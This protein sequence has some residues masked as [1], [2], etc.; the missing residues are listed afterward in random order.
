MSIKV[1][2]LRSGVILHCDQEG[3]PYLA[4]L[5]N[6]QRVRKRESSLIWSWQTRRR[7]TLTVVKAAERR[8]S[9]RSQSLFDICRLV[10]R[11]PMMCSPAAMTDERLF[12]LPTDHQTSIW[13][14]WWWL[15]GVLVWMELVLWSLFWPSCSKNSHF[16]SLI[17][18][19]SIPK[20]CVLWPR[21]KV[22]YVTVCVQD[23]NGISLLCRNTGKYHFQKRPQVTEN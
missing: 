8:P 16:H 2:F 22:V 4:M 10:W 20:N 6:E 11:F 21:H 15:M 19:M 1:I 14:C 18:H 3:E 7:H 12:R 17:W 5:T 13:L 23:A 9:G